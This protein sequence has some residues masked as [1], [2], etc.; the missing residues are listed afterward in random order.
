MEGK[1]RGK[2]W[3]SDNV[4]EEGILKK[5]EERT[6]YGKRESKGVSREV[7]RGMEKVEG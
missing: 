7:E 2:G 4:E 6:Q 3:I 1:A 5:G